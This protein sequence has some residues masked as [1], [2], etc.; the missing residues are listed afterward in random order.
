MLATA[1]RRLSRSAR[2]SVSYGLSVGSLE[3]TKTGRMEWARKLVYH[4]GDRE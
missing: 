1:I 4:V 2:P 3:Y